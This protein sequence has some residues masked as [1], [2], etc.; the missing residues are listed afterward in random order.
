MIYFDLDGVIRDLCSIVFGFE[1]IKW[2]Y[3]NKEGKTLVDIINENMGIL[4]DA[5][6]TKYL[7]FIKP[8]SPLVILSSKCPEKWKIRTRGWVNKY[9]P[10]SE[11]H[12]INPK[13]KQNFLNKGDFLV[14]DSP[15]LTS[16]ENII[17]IDRKYNKNIL[18]YKRVKTGYQLKKILIEHY[19]NNCINCKYIGDLSKYNDEERLMYEKQLLFPC[20]NPN[21]KYSFVRK[22]FKCNKFVYKKF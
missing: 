10:R 2:D 5:P 11:L 9:L 12:F 13:T 21:S 7:P 22:E 14:E 3:Q 16:Y 8:F 4:R 1:P 15:N 17:L 19:A 18:P 6:P 20:N